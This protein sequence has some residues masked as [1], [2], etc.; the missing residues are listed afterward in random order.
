MAATPE[1]KVKAKIKDYLMS[2][3][4]CFFFSPIGGPYTTAGI[5]DI[6]VCLKGRFVAIEVKAPGKTKN[7]TPLQDYALGRIRQTGGIAFVAD[8]VDTVKTKLSLEG[9]VIP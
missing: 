6:V 3:A 5:P 9:L 4:D 2:L 1:A 8:S 7:T